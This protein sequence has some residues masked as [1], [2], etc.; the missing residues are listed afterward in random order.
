MK[1]NNEL[2]IQNH[3]LR[4]LLLVSKFIDLTEDEKVAILSHDGFY[5]YSNREYWMRPN[6]LMMLIHFADLYCARIV[7]VET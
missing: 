3:A 1:I 5:E 7:E 6:E 4:S 2:Q